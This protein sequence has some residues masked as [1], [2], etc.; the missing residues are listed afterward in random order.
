MKFLGNIL[1]LIF[2]GIIIAFVYYLVGLLMCITII[3]EEH[4][5]ALAVKG[6]GVVVDASQWILK[7]LNGLAPAAKVPGAGHDDVVALPGAVVADIGAV[8]VAGAVGDVGI[9]EVVLVQ[10]VGD[11]LPRFTSGSPSVKA[12]LR[13]QAR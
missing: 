12:E 6:D 11:F 5:I 8:A 10:D 13:R 2:G 9:D 3:G 4:D 1:W 7:D